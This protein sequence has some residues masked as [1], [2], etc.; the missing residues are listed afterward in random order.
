MEKIKLKNILEKVE[1]I[2]Q[3]KSSGLDLYSTLL[4]IE[5]NIDNLNSVLE[6]IL[7]KILALDTIEKI[8]DK[9][10]P[11]YPPPEYIIN[12][13][14]Q[15]FKKTGQIEY[16][17]FSIEGFA[18]SLE[19]TYSSFVIK[20]NKSTLHTTIVS[21]YGEFYSKEHFFVIGRKDKEIFGEKASIGG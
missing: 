3:E 8:K 17:G 18:E 7:R 6:N 16:I 1:N 4:H 21:F 5:K 2:Y 13:I 11:L 9:I 20:L 14:K 15:R 12:Y 10:L 19:I